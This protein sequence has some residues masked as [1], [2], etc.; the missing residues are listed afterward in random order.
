[1]VFFYF[2]FVLGNNVLCFIES[3]YNIFN[4]SLNRSLPIIIGAYRYIYV[5][6]WDKVI[7]ETDKKKV[8]ILLTIFLFFLPLCSS[9]GHIFYAGF[10]LRLN[11]CMG[12]EENFFYDFHDVFV[13]SIGPLL[14]RYQFSFFNSINLVI[15]ISF[16]Y[17]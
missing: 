12:R 17:F 15:I 11:V 8:H 7:T 13:S 14:S 6:H 4:L 2:R 9:I 3:I 10:T 5:F 1:M 16:I